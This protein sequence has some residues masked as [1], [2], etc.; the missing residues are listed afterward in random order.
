MSE[1][2]IRELDL[3]SGLV[4]I[5]FPVVLFISDLYSGNVPAVQFLVSL[6]A[7]WFLGA[8]LVALA[9]LAWSTNPRLVIV[10]GALALLGIFG[11]VGIMV[12]RFVTGTIRQTDGAIGNAAQFEAAIHKTQPL[13]FTFGLLPPLVL[14]LLSAVL[15]RHEKKAKWAWAIV[16][17]GILL[18]PA[19]RISLGQTVVLISDSLLLIGLGFAGWQLLTGRQKLEAENSGKTARI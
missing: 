13:I 14:C 11:S 5:A 19:G 7:V 17:V 10:A 9:R 8:S 2:L 18:F 16:C 12:F 15:L 4:L 1:R 3:L 6:C